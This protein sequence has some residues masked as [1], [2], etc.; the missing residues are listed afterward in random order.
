MHRQPCTW[1]SDIHIHGHA[2]ECG[3][4][5]QVGRGGAKSLVRRG[6]SGLTAR[7]EAP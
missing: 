7:E 3:P 4:V 6:L 5:R 1:A 2:R